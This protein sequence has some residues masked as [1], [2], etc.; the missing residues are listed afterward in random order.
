M[1]KAISALK[2][3]AEHRRSLIRG[4]Q[5]KSQ[6]WNIGNQHLCVQMVDGIS[7]FL[8]KE[9]QY[10]EIVIQYMEKENHLLANIQRNTTISVEIVGIV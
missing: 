8:S 6:P 2:D 4:F 3:L 5:D 7:E 1:K 10:L 9:I